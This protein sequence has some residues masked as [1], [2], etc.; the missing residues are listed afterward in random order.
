MLTDRTNAAPTKS[1]ATPYLN[2]AN[3]GMI[4]CAMIPQRKL[5]KTV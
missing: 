5:G 3:W 4:E 1:S 2:I